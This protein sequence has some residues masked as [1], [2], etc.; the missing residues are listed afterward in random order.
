MT[1]VVM[2]TRTRSTRSPVRARTPSRLT[3]AELD[4]LLPSETLQPSKEARSPAA[5]SDALFRSPVLPLRLVWPL[6]VT[7][8]SW[9]GVTW[10]AVRCASR[11]PGD[12][13][14]TSLA[15]IQFLTATCSWLHWLDARSGWRCATDK[16]VART[17]FGLFTVA[18]LTRIRDAQLCLLGWP[19]WVVLVLCYRASLRYWESDGLS[20]SRWVGAHAGFH[21][22][23]GIGQCVI[24]H[25][26]A[27]AYQRA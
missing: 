20:R 8:L 13:A 5:W 16:L 9:Y 17:S 10:F 4:A 11:A 24:L 27:E 1:Q 2:T 12:S 15:A 21:C 25:G 3:D 23:V 18:A 7:S 6:V 22:C 26:I 19:L 14:L